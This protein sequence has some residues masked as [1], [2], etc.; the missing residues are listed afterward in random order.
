MPAEGTNL[1]GWRQKGIGLKPPFGPASWA[2]VPTGQHKKW[3]PVYALG[4]VIG[5]ELWVRESESFIIV[6][7]PAWSLSLRETLLYQRV[8]RLGFQKK[9][10]SA[11]SKT[12]NRPILGSRGRYYVYLSKFVHMQTCLE[13]KSNTKTISSSALKMSRNMRHS[14]EIVC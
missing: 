5:Q 6:S 11:F 4:S 8:N 9:S 1:M 7:G 13:I 3:K 2:P 14:R 10:L 12:G